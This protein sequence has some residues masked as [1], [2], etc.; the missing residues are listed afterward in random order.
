M[1]KNSNFYIFIGKTKLHQYETIEFH[2]LGNAVST[3][4]I[5]A[6]NLVRYSPI[7]LIYIETSMPTSNKSGLRP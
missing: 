5:A 1:K 7:F 3:S 6:E 2:A 4:V